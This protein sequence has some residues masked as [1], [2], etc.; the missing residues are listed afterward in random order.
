MVCVFAVLLTVVAY[1]LA[2]VK[3][4]LMVKYYLYGES[5]EWSLQHSGC[6]HVPAEQ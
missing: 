6:R 2:Y 5:A 1:L 3:M 4:P